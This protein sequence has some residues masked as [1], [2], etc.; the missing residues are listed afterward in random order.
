MATIP[1]I[2]YLR[3]DGRPTPV[4]IDR[5]EHIAK[6]ADNIRAHGFRFECEMLATGY[7]SF[8]ISDEFD[9]YAIKVCMNGPTVP[10]TVDSLISSFNLGEALKARKALQGN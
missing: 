3:P 2:Q 4:A 9:D 6:A 1:F 8:T 5:P 10:G 7:V